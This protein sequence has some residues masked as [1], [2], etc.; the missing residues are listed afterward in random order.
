MAVLDRD[1]LERSPLADLHAIA[2]ELGVEGFRRLRREDLVSA[3]VE[4]AGNGEAPAKKSGRD[5]ATPSEDAGRRRRTGG[6]R[7]GRRLAEAEKPDEKGRP[8]RRRG[9]RG[10]S[11]RPEREPAARPSPRPGKETEPTDDD[12]EAE[13][14][15][16]TGVLDILPNGSGFLRGDTLAPD[17]GDV[18]VS[19]AQ[20]RRCELRP[21]DMV[22]GPV[23]APRR[24]ERHPSLVHVETVNGAPAEPPPERST[25]GEPTPAY[26]IERLAAPDELAAVPFGKGSRVAV[27][28]PPGAEAGALLRR[29][30]ATLRESHPELA[31]VVALAGGRPEDAAQWR[32][33]GELAVVGGG[34]DGSIDEQSQAAELALER[35][36]RLVEGGAHAVVVVD[37][38][39][40]IAPDAARRIFAAAR[41]H[42]GAGSLTVI[43][44]LAVSDELARLA[45]TRIVL[46]PGT[47]S[48]GDE[49]PAVSPA[50]STVRADL[51]GG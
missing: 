28:D 27:V 34:A 14:E 47:G 7:G 22:A 42:D 35:A 12:A 44:T 2:A 29:M 1:E 26:A 23:R 39:E 36:K 30:V 11:E 50:S 17:R 21:G 3:I 37:S 41:R 4:H 43:G 51:L 45:T 15:P 25:F 48:R 5:A 6:G 40:A 38:L 49:P 19:P 8:A 33:D 20:I 46:E 32:Q 24:S 10:R 13:T 18:H 31:V 9:G 16:R